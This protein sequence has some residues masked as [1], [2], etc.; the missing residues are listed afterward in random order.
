MGSFVDMAR[1]EYAEYGFDTLPLLPGSK[2]AF[3]HSWQI[4]TPYRLWQNAPD[5]A[6]IAIRGGGLAKVAMID[7]DELR[8]FENITNWLSGLGY[9]AGDYPIV[10]TPS[11]AGRC[12]IYATF[13]GG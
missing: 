11:G 4:R 12:H 5:G 10:Q 6:N 1:M 3:P 2:K 13:A 8:T 9:H 7:C